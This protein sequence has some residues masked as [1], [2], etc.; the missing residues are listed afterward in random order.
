MVHELF[1]EKSPYFAMFK[2]V[3]EEFQDPPTDP[4]PHQSLIGQDP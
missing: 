1:A 4:A 3:G 2:K